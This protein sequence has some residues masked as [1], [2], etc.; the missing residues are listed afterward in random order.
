MRCP[1]CNAEMTRRLGDHH[2]TESGLDN[3]FLHQVE[4]FDCPCGEQ[5]VGIPNL[6]RL[7]DLIAKTILGKKALLTGQEIKFLRKNMGLTALALAKLLGVNNATISRWEHDEHPIQEP[8]DRLLRL[9]YA[10]NKGISAGDL[11]RDFPEIQAQQTA[12]AQIDLT[13]ENWQAA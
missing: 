1:S 7:H 6:P 10:L 13:S 8:T 4:I 12:P 5:V 3:V 11:M 9:V 2:Y